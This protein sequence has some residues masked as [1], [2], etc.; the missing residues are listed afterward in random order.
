MSGVHPAGH[1]AHAARSASAPVVSLG[2]MYIPI[3]LKRSYPVTSW[4]VR[5]LG[6]TTLAASTSKELCPSFHSRAIPPWL[7]LVAFD[8]M[9][10]YPD[11]YFGYLSVA[12]GDSTSR[13]AQDR[14][15][16]QTER[17]SATC[18]RGGP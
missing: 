7:W 8:E 6:V 2:G 17:G 5:R 3:T 15:G 11:A 4:K 18:T 9:I 10:L 14:W 12:G 16:A 13:V 1:A